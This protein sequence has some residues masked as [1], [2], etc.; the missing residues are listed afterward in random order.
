VALLSTE[1][2][3][4]STA[5]SFQRAGDARLAPFTLR[6]QHA[7]GATVMGAVLP[8]T[9]TVL[10]VAGVVPSRDESW[11]SALFR[12]DEGREPRLLADR[13]Y[14]STRPLVTAGGRV[15]VQR[16]RAGTE[17]SFEQARAGEL[18]EDELTVDEVNPK[19]GEARTVHAT[20]GYLTFL[21]GAL[22]DELF[23][24]RVRFHHADL[25]AVNADSGAVRVLAA[26]IEP[27]ARDFSVDAET[28]ALLYTQLDA[29]TGEWV[30]ERLDLSTLARSTLAR[31]PL[32][33]LAAHA[34]P[35]GKLAVN[36]KGD[37]GLSVL[38]ADAVAGAPFGPGVDFLH[39]FTRDGRFVA[40]LHTT[41]SA[42]PRPFVLRTSTGEPLLLATVPGARVD[43]AGFVEAGAR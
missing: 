41:P 23:V 29:R 8:G 9:R 40:G 35:G 37:Q 20:T 24:Y 5:L 2:G 17:P 18:R 34:W 27:F 4:D 1:P 42:L 26:P 3:A 39:A 10:A 43:V 32:M 11:A 38:G 30:V 13:V 14:L 22:G 15:F 28:K 36:L 31:A 7:A 16:G 6:L 21:A 12:L 25:I 33:A 19:T